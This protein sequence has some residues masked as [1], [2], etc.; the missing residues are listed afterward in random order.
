L[1]LQHNNQGGSQQSS[2]GIKAVFPDILEQGYRGQTYGQDPYRIDP[3]SAGVMDGIASMRLFSEDPELYAYS[4]GLQM[5]NDECGFRCLSA[6]AFMLGRLDRHEET[7]SMEEVKKGV[8]NDYV[9]VFRATWR[10]ILDSAAALIKPRPKLQLECPTAA[11]HATPGKTIDPSSDSSL[12]SLSG[13]DSEIVITTIKTG[14]KRSK[15]PRLQT[16]TKRKTSRFFKTS[17]DESPL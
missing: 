14:A 16:G 2:A 8:Q 15:A 11:P 9:R 12:T 5:D 3:S 10:R 17:V 6:A 4:T 13:S 7:P 1:G